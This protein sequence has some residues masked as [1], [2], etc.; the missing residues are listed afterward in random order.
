MMKRNLLVTALVAL[1][2]FAACSGDRYP[3]VNAKVV[4]IEYYDTIKVDEW[5]LIDGMKFEHFDDYELSKSDS[6]TD[7]SEFMAKNVLPATIQDIEI[8]GAEEKIFQKVYDRSS[9]MYELFK[10]LAMKEDEEGN[11]LYSFLGNSL[12]VAQG[13]I[14]FKR[15]DDE[16]IKVSTSDGYGAAV[17]KIE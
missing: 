2:C 11:R 5:I 17:R 10:R 9:I 13:K 1:F 8:P 12:D 6:T 7:D 14:K 16:K 15:L 3:Y 4:E